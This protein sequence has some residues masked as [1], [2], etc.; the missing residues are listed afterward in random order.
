MK[1][2]VLIVLSLV[3]LVSVVAVP[4]GAAAADTVQPRW[5]NTSTVDCLITY[6]D[7][8]GYAESMVQGK[9]GTSAIT[10]DIYLYKYVNDDWGY[11]DEF[12]ETLYKRAALSSLPFE[13]NVGEYFKADYTF[14]VTKGGTDEVITRT[15]Y[16]TIPQE[17]N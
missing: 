5:T 16:Y 11:V 9:F 12:H 4:V 1:K 7:G 14:T 8:V 2:V 10:T 6:V 17:T 13:A 15:V 3:M